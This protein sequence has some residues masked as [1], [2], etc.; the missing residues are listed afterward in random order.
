MMLSVEDLCVPRNEHG[1][2]ICTFWRLVHK[3]GPMY[4]AVDKP[5]LQR[6]RAA[7]SIMLHVL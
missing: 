3:R 2:K 5:H 7:R 6:T 4:L 1:T